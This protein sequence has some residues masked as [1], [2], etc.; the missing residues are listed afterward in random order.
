MATVRAVFLGFLAS[1]N[2]I[3]LAVGRLSH[4]GPDAG[5]VAKQIEFSSWSR[6]GSSPCPVWP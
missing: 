6:S 5:P 2:W 3:T 1:A 4:L